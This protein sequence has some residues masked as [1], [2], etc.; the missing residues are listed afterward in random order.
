MLCGEKNRYYI[1]SCSGDSS[2]LILNVI[3]W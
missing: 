1:R 3:N 2:L